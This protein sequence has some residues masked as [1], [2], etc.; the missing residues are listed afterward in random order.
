M[1]KFPLVDHQILIRKWK[2][3][4]WPAEA[5]VDC[6]LNYIYCTAL[7]LQEKPLFT[8]YYFALSRLHR[9]HPYQVNQRNQQQPALG[10]VAS[11][12]FHFSGMFLDPHCA[13]RNQSLMDHSKQFNDPEFTP[14]LDNDP[15]SR[16]RITNPLTV[17][18]VVVCRDERVAVQ[19]LCR[20][21]APAYR[22]RL[23]A[24]VQCFRWLINR[25]FSCRMLAP[26]R[27]GW[28]LDGISSSRF[29]NNFLQYQ[30]KRVRWWNM[31]IPDQPEWCFA[32]YQP[33]SCATAFC[34]V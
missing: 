25:V 10:G 12:C 15:V 26:T 2:S 6:I 11:C 32:R 17:D 18:V 34:C 22:S 13:T 1:I 9:A 3:M 19:Q 24:L 5:V 33:N 30:P 4:K 7:W 8:S 16:L 23:Y 27:S 28:F 29:R 14:V 31:E 21:V 20:C